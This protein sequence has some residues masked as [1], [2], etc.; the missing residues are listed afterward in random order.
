MTSLTHNTW[1]SGTISAEAVWYSFSVSDGNIYGIQWDDAYDGSGNY[2]GDI[3]VSAYYDDEPTAIFEAVD[4][5]NTTPQYVTAT[6]TGSI[7]FKVEPYGPAYA[8]SY[9]IIYYSY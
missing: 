3:K 8:G 5:A 6:R 4:S 9:A 7:R 1:A 2:T